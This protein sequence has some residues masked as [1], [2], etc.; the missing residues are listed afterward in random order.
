M[1]NI[2]TPKIFGGEIV[3]SKFLSANKKN[4]PESAQ[5]KNRRC[6]IWHS[7]IYQI[8]LSEICRRF[9]NE[10]RIYSYVSVLK[11]YIPIKTKSKGEY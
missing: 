4:V 5:G 9:I 1:H 3:L 2:I 10:W 11:R 7:G 8:V 6:Q